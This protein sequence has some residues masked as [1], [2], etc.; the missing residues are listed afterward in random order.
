MR[1]A[2]EHYGTVKAGAQE[3]LAKIGIW[4]GR[5]PDPPASVHPDRLWSCHAVCRAVKVQF[6]L[7]DWQVVDGCFARRGVQHA[8]LLRNDKAVVIDV[9]P[10]ASM[11]GPILVDVASILS[12]W[13]GMYLP[14]VMRF[15]YSAIKLERFNAEATL[16]LSMAN[17]ELVLREE[18]L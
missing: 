10:V 5:V 4:L 18:R 12:P 9:Y 17:R 16:M 1:T 11:G 15:Y 6:K 14:E 7:D 3:T 2:L 13:H 8:W